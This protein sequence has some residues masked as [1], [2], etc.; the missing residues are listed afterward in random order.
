[1]FQMYIRKLYIDFCHIVAD[2]NP[3][4]REGGG[5]VVNGINGELLKGFTIFSIEKVAILRH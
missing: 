5:G 3:A 4:R 2:L 1:M